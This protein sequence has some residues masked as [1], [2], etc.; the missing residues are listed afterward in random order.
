[1]PIE[2]ARTSRIKA[3]KTTQ[4]QDHGW[5]KVVKSHGIDRRFIHQ[6][7]RNVVADRIH[8]FTL[9]TLQ[10]LAIFFLN[11]RLF[12]GGTNQNVEKILGNHGSIL[13][14]TWRGQRDARIHV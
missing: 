8:A 12:A 5:L 6:K 4:T 1:V 9:S 13:R 7:N 14:Q 11:E 10:A 2:V 3:D